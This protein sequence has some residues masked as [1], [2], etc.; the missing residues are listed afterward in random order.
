MLPSETPQRISRLTPLDD[1]LARIDALV[2]P[3]AAC[4]AEPA[5]ALGRTLAEDILIEARIPAGALA[6][7]DGWAV[8]SE[9]TNDAGPYAPAPLP[10]ATRIDVGEPL[11]LAAD[12]VAPLD[13]VIIRNDMPQVL[14]PVAPGDGVLM[15]G[16]DLP[17]GSIRLG[18]GCR[19]GR[20]QVALLASA[21][22]RHIEV[23]EP[24]LRLARARPK[25]DVVIDAALACLAD[26]I[27]CESGQALVAGMKEELDSAIRDEGADGVIIVGGTGSGRRDAAVR[28]LQQ[29]GKVEV[30][31]VGLV[32]G[33]T[34]A[35]GSVAG[36]PVLALPGRLDAALAG[37]HMLGRR[38]LR[39][40]TGSSEELVLRMAKLKHK[41][42]S[43][44][45]LAELI[46]VRC[47]NGFATPIASGYVPLAALAQAN[48]W[49]FI[50]AESEGY[51]AGSEVVIR[52]WP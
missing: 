51:P 47:E 13:A 30:H 41:V 40:L 17:H 31:G 39:R 10:A 21:G 26:A 46:A 1:V 5:D 38:I 44:V 20:L 37:W 7:R 42:S 15:A 34:T 4:S 19:L 23:R 12:A 43:A 2:N 50:R 6:L 18:A 3:V 33:E 16:A 25:P 45:G 9:L 11:P 48:G 52:P 29:V 35:F 49:I 24:R 22:R 28:T 32:P 14:E 36:R 8:H 27:R